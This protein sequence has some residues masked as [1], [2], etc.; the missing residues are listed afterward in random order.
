MASI[1]S[2]PPTNSAK[3]KPLVCDEMSPFYWDQGTNPDATIADV[4]A[5]A[6]KPGATVNDVRAL[7]GDTDNTIIQ[8]KKI[9]AVGISL[10]GWKPDR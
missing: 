6:V 9:N 4:L 7:V 2:T 3:L 5:V 10:C 8:A 1:V